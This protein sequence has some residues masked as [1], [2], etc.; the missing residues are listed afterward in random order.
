MYCQRVRSRKTRGR[1]HGDKRIFMPVGGIAGRHDRRH[2]NK[3]KMEFGVKIN[4]SEVNGFCRTDRFSWDARPD[5]S[6]HF[7]GQR[8]FQK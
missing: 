7:S 3:L 1:E 2:K 8:F 4:I 6:G 5:V